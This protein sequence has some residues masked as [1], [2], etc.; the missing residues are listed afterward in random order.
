MLQQIQQLVSFCS[1]TLTPQSVCKSTAA[2]AAI[3]S[4]ASDFLSIFSHAADGR[5]IEAKAGLPPPYQPRPTRQLSYWPFIVVPSLLSLRC[6]P[7]VTIP[8][9]LSLCYCPFVTVALA[10]VLSLLAINPS[11]LAIDPSLLAH[12]TLAHHTTYRATVQSSLCNIV[13]S[14]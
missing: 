7:F 13:G 6:C 2:S 3:N 12:S 10:I 11:L 5:S 14:T 9:Q 1:L 8:S 4:D